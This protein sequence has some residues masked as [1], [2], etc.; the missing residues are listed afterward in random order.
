MVKAEGMRRGDQISIVLVPMWTLLL[1][2]L[3]P[4]LASVRSLF[5]CAQYVPLPT[6]AN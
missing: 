4:F 1:A 3:Y 2:S 6:A 5:L